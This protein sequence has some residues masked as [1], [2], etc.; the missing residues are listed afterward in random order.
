[1]VHTHAL[2][3]D[4]V[5]PGR[6]DRRVAGYLVGIRQIQKIE[7]VNAHEMTMHCKVMR[8]EMPFYYSSASNLMI[9]SKKQRDAEG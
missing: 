6:E 2:C 8:L 7:V 9:F 3:R 4:L 1:M 5:Y